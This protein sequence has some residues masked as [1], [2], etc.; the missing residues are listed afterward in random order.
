MQTGYDGPRIWKQLVHLQAGQLPL[1]IAYALPSFA[2]ELDLDREAELR[3]E[4]ITL[5][6]RNLI[7]IDPA[8]WIDKPYVCSD[9][10][11]PPLLFSA[12]FLYQGAYAVN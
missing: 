6:M 8:T 3:Q 5:V 1:I 4:A 2:E 10:N 7:A 11:Y 9:A 12:A